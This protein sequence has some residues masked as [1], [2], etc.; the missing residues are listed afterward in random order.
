M[1][2]EL[3]RPGF[4]RTAVRAFA[5]RGRGAGQ[6]EAA[7]LVGPARHHFLRHHAAHAVADQDHIAALQRVNEVDTA[8]R[9][10]LEG[11]GLDRCTAPV[12]GH[13]P[14]DGPVAG[15]SQGFHLRCER[16]VTAADAVQ[17][18]HGGATTQDGE[19]GQTVHSA[20]LP[21][22][23]TTVSSSVTVQPRMGK[24]K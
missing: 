19:S 16:Q 10:A 23:M 20:T 2:D 1:V 14:G 6:H 5:E 9:Q 8:L 24:S 3:T 7:D 13:V 17:H 4:G 12:A 21:A 11:V 18:E 22:S 15:T